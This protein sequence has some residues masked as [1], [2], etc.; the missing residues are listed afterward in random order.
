MPLE[1]TEGRTGMSLRFWKSQA[2]KVRGCDINWTTKI[3]REYQE[4]DPN[5]VVNGLTLLFKL[6]Y[7]CLL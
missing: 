1:R 7:L 4:T 6:L 3:L 2:E 5:E